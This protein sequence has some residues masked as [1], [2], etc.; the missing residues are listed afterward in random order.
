VRQSR[1][2]WEPTVFTESASRTDGG[3]LESVSG[4]CHFREIG[5]DMTRMFIVALISAIVSA[6]FA[7]SVQYLIATVL[8]KETMSGEEEKK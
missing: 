3:G 8:S 4:F 6:P 1:C 7:L 5:E 2:Y